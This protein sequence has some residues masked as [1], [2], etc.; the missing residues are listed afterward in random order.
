MKKFTL[1]FVLFLAVAVFVGGSQ[2]HAQITTADVS[3]SYQ[4]TVRPVGFFEKVKLF[5]TANPEKKVN[6]LQDF[7]NR[8]F[9]LA[10]LKLAEG[11][12]NEASVFFRKSDDYTLRATIAISKIKDEEKR[13]AEQNSISVTASNRIV[14]LTAAKANVENPVAKEAIQNAID[15]QVGVDASVKAGISLTPPGLSGNTEASVC[16]VNSP[17]SIKVLSPNGGE[18]FQAGQQITV[19]WKSCNVTP[20]SIGIILIK[21][22]S[23]VSYTQSE[24]P[25][26]YAGFALGGF[27]PYTG[28]A[29]DGSNPPRA[30]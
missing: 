28:T 18:V 14:A 29:D 27:D 12:A 6:L 3:S 17:S 1:G 16:N 11:K 25:G 30:N 21:H 2:A 8:N 19:K 22:D 15:R 20:G 24:G 26:D 7:S 5:F 4:I 13:N 23:S 9:E 10:K